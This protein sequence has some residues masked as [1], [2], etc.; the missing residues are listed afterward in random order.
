[1]TMWRSKRGQDVDEEQAKKL[2]AITIV[3]EI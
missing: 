3:F 2:E 1:M